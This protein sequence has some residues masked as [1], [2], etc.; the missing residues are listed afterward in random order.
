MLFK[1]PNVP[2]YLKS[3]F[4]DETKTLYYAR[5]PF[6]YRQTI[7]LINIDQ[8]PYEQEEDYHYINDLKYWNERV[9]CL[10]NLYIY[11]YDFKTKKKFKSKY[12]YR[13]MELDFTMQALP[14]YDD[15]SGTII[16]TGR[17][18]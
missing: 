15:G 13:S 17:G 14:D 10:T 3:S 1:L 2:F 6:I 11:V 12:N 7:G 8:V 16:N 9:Y 18:A 4:D 5:S